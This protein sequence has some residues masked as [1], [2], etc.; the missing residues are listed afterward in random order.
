MANAPYVA[1]DYSKFV[2]LGPLIAEG[3]R[4]VFGERYAETDRWSGWSLTADDR[5]KPATTEIQVEHLR[6]LVSIREDLIPYL[7]LP[8]G[9]TFSIFADGSWHE[10]SP[11]DRLITWI[12]HFVSGRE[13]GPDD[14]TAIAELIGE[15]FQATELETRVVQPLLDWVSQGA[16]SSSEVRDL[17]VWALDRLRSDPAR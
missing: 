1:P 5:P 17:L 12:D 16:R 2:W 13:A 4:L 7:G 6:H 10:W 8:V 15:Q 9:W 14:A 3:H 11:K